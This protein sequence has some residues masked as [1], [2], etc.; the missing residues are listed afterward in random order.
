VRENTAQC[1]E[2]MSVQCRTPFSVDN[3]SSAPP[4]SIDNPSSGLDDSICSNSSTENMVRGDD[5]SDM[6]KEKDDEYFIFAGGGSI[7]FHGYLLIPY[8]WHINPRIL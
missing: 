4:A 1:E 6:S 3:P 2:L 5:D 7:I 8:I